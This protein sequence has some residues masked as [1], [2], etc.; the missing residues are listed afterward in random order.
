MSQDVIV[1]TVEG[2]GRTASPAAVEAA[3]AR[4]AGVRSVSMN[5]ASG[6]IRISFDSRQVG[7]ADLAAVVCAAGCGLHRP[8]IET[9]GTLPPQ[10]NRTRDC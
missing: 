3:L 8:P 9:L 10:A 6:R 4:T 7:L 2:L 5:V 1:L